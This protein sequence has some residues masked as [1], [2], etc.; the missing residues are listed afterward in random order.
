[1]LVLVGLGKVPQVTELPLAKV[2]FKIPDQVALA[3]P[4]LHDE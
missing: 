1:M 4:K 3:E 2:I